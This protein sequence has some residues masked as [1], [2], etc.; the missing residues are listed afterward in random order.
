VRSWYAHLEHRGQTIDGAGMVDVDDWLDGRQIAAR[1]RYGLI[2]HL[3]MFY[4]WAQRYGHATSDPTALVERPRLER[5]YPRPA[6]KAA[7]N[8]A[9]DMA[10]P[11]LAAWLALM[12]DAG[13]RCMEVAGLHWDHVDL[14]AGVI[15][16][17]DGK[18]GHDRIV[19]IPQRL[20]AR[21]AALDTTTGLVVGRHLRPGRVSQI[22]NAYLEARGVEATAHQLRHLYATR[23]YAAT[24]GNLLAVQ[25]ALGH[26]S[27]TSTQIYAAIDPTRA[28]AAAQQLD[29]EAGT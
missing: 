10:T 2:S 5:R 27:V 6:R 24:N 21:L 22:V 4:I 17:R 23:L 18:G 9:I 29:A 1:G 8:M 16:V 26:A 13:L 14:E 19:G 15:L 11:E 3:H 25:H 20:R 12:A 7:V 28:I